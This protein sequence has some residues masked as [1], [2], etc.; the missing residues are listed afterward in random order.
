MEILIPLSFL[1]ILIIMAVI[2]FKLKHAKESGFLALV[3]QERN[4]VDVKL[5]NKMI[6]TPVAVS[7]NGYIG[8]YQPKQK[9]LLVLHI[10]N[11]NEFDL[12][13]DNKSGL[14]AVVAG[15]LLFGAA[16]A[17][18]G[19]AMSEKKKSIDL[20]IKTTDFNNPQVVI[21]LFFATSS[22]DGRREHAMNEI[23]KLMSSIDNIFQAQISGQAT[24]QMVTQQTSG[25]DEL[26]KFKK[27]LDDGTIS[28]E[29][30]DTKKKQL[31]GL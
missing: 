4:F 12:L 22:N 10:S 26:S 7:R 5:F 8:I 27:L 2:G 25:A 20:Q 17:I 13:I 3:E 15:G 24:A 28:Q 1:A 6:I 16:G 11:I 31:L 18:V 21:P 30:F 9:N 23:H 14:G 29:E 19:K